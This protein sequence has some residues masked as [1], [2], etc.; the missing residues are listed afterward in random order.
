M[1]LSWDNEIPSSF[2]IFLLL[3]TTTAH[4]LMPNSMAISSLKISTVWTS[5]SKPFSFLAYKFKSFMNRRWFIFSLLLENWYAFSHVRKIT[6]NRTRQSTNNKDESDSPWNIPR[7]I[8]TPPG[9]WLLHA[10]STLHA[11]ILSDKKC[12]ICSL[13]QPYQDTLQSWS[14]EQY[15]MISYNQS[16]RLLGFSFSFKPQL[17]RVEPFSFCT[18]SADSLLH[19]FPYNFESLSLKSVSC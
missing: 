16:M 2:V 5:D 3:R 12:L 19:F 1:T 4:L 11:F 14:V 15:H 7:F 9:D 10:K 13:T 18:H 17:L 8:P 6:V